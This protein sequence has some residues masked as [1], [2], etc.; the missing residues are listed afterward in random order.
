VDISD[1]ATHDVAGIFKIWFRQLPTSVI[2]RMLL[3]KFV[4]CNEIED[5][6][7][8]LDQCREIIGKQLPSNNARVLSFTLNFLHNFVQQASESLMDASNLATIF[9]PSLFFCLNQP[10]QTKEEIL[11]NARLGPA[12]KV[13][14]A[15][16]IDNAPELFDND[17]TSQSLQ[18]IAK[19]SSGNH[20]L[21]NNTNE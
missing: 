19:D 13:C 11:E 9:A 5:D 15:F 2:P 7:E 6:A 1:A 3:D 4:A 8:R 10:D 17:N 16:M 14:I 18:S 21:L 12:T 20:S